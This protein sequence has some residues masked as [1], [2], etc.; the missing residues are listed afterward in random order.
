MSFAVRNYG[1]CC[2]LMV[3]LCPAFF[4][5]VDKWEVIYQADRAGLGLGEGGGQCPGFAWWR[6]ESGAPSLAN[7]KREKVQKWDVGSLEPILRHFQT[8]FFYFFSG[9]L[10]MF[11]QI[12]KSRSIHMWIKSSLH[13]PLSF[14]LSLS[15]SFVLSSPLTCRG[16][17]ER[18]SVIHSVANYNLIIHCKCRD[19]Q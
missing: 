13:V 8:C 14:S 16:V 17:C 10:W 11:S 6:A 15:Y 3:E 19:R 4:V 18:S 5:A 9:V 2:L 1:S 12:Q 7:E